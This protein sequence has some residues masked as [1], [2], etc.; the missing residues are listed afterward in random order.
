MQLKIRRIIYFPFFNTGGRDL[1]KINQFFNLCALQ[2]F[3]FNWSVRAVEDNNVRQHLLE[4]YYRF[5][6]IGGTEMEKTNKCLLNRPYITFLSI[7]LIESC[8]VEEL[9]WVEWAIN[10]L[11]VNLFD[12]R[13]SNS[14]QKCWQRYRVTLEPSYGQIRMQTEKLATWWAVWLKHIAFMAYAH[15]TKAGCESAKSFK[16][17]SHI[18]DFACTWLILYSRIIEVDIIEW[19]N[20]ATNLNISNIWLC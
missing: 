12:H 9:S 19:Y 15:I 11:A 6:N 13:L 18:S 16:S 7:K 14:W 2:T 8:A 3:H 20:Y 17:M 4:Q 1:E 10:Y 5:L